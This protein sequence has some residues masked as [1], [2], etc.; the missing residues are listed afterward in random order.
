MNT[1]SIL[2]LVALS[3][4]SVMG[5]YVLVNPSYQKSIQAK[6]FYEIGNYKEALSLAKESFS[7][8]VY[9]RMA[10]TVMAQSVTALKYVSYIEMGK[11]YMAEINLIAT[12]ENITD[13]DKAKIRIM[14]E[15]MNTEYVKLAPS[16]I[17]DESL[18]KETAEY[19]QKFEKLLEKVTR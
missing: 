12:H 11:K 16:V 14:C 4:V 19:N 1:K 5:V 6:Y 10:S 9:N 15:I 18:V 8:D 17:T 3:L 2:A 13:A 7:M